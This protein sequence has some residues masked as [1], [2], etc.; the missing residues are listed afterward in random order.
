LRSVVQRV[1]ERAALRDTTRLAEGMRLAEAHAE[2][3]DP[4]LGVAA[5]AIEQPP[6]ELTPRG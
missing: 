4:L 1:V 5:K 6:A 3:Q 2:E